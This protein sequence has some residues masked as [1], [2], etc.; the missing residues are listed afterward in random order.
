MVENADKPK[1]QALNRRRLLLGAAAATAVSVTPQLLSSKT[2]HE[3]NDQSFTERFEEWEPIGLG[4]GRTARIMG[5]AHHPNAITKNHDVFLDRI[6][7]S[8]LVI[9]EGTI[10]ERT[11]RAAHTIAQGEQPADKMSGFSVFY[12]VITGLA[13]REGKRV[14]VIDPDYTKYSLADSVMDTYG[15]YTILLG[16]ISKKDPVAGAS[17][18]HATSGLKSILENEARRHSDALRNQISQ[19]KS[20]DIV[21]IAW[22]FADWRDVRVSQAIR[23]FAQLSNGAFPAKATAQIFRGSLHGPGLHH[24]L[25]APVE[26]SA[27]RLTYPHWEIMQQ[28]FG[29][30]TTNSRD[31]IREITLEGIKGV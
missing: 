12:A 29:E 18:I 6:R 21:R 30:G 28:L 20:K 22:D 7:K 23:E 10:N 9:I 13:L 3:G 8:D 26:A 19:F 24:Y 4:D 31:I 25:K 16:E 2:A 5:V 11:V 15:M 14:F 17:A 1:K 27:K